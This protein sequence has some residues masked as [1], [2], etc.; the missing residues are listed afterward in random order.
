[1]LRYA[2]RRLVLLIPVLIGITAVVFFLIH[3]I[4]GDP[5][6]VLLG[7]DNATPQAV[8]TLRHQLGLDRPLFV[9]YLIYLGNT[10]RGRKSVV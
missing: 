4:P 1:M 9:Q 7:P 2:V 3:L 5:V 10:L 8:A 6:L